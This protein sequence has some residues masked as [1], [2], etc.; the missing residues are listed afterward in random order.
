MKQIPL[1][2]IPAQTFSVIL[3]D[4]LCVISIYWRQERLYLDLSSNDI[5]IC[6]GAICQNKADIVQSRSQ[7]FTGKLFFFDTEGDRPPYW[8]GLN[9][10]DI[11]LYVS[12]GEESP[13]F[14]G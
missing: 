3:D 10:R 5:I 11:L 8:E 4:Q 12:E 1:T 2:N 6:L 13:D 14:L 9:S 7:L